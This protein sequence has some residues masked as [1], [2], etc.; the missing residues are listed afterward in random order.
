MF[1]DVEYD[2]KVLFE[3]YNYD[4]IRFFLWGRWLDLKGM[5]DYIYDNKMKLIFW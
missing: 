2:E 1:N 5:V 3:V 4:E